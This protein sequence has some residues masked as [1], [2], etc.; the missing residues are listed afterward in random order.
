MS[1]EEYLRQNIDATA[2]QRA[3]EFAESS[4]YSEIQKLLASETYKMAQEAL[5]AR[6]ALIHKDTL[7]QIKILQEQIQSSGFYSIHKEQMRRLKSEQ[8]AMQGMVGNL[9]KKDDS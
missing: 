6:D 8:D 7:E 4:H 2:I 9:V 5:R 3:K 1:V